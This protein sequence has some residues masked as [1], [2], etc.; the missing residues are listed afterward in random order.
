MFAANCSKRMGQCKNV[1]VF[2]QGGTK[3]QV[4]DVDRNCKNTRSVVT[5]D[6]ARLSSDTDGARHRK[7][8]T[9]GTFTTQCYTAIGH[10][11]PSLHSFSDL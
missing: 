4:S 10:L 6:N 3:V 2:T 8:G 1:F 5:L 11:R 7:L 9:K